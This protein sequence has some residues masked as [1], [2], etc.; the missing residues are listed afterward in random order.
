MIWCYHFETDTVPVQKRRF[1]WDFMQRFFIPGNGTCPAWTTWMMMIWQT[2][3]TSWRS[4]PQWE[5]SG[6]FFWDYRWCSNCANQKPTFTNFCG[7]NNAINHP[8]LGMVNIAPSCGD[9]WGMVYLDF[10]LISSSITVCFLAPQLR[11]RLPCRWLPWTAANLPLGFATP[12][13]LRG[14]I[15]RGSSVSPQRVKRMMTRS[16]LYPD[17]MILD[18][19]YGMILGWYRISGWWFGTFFFTYIGNNHPN[20]L[21]FFRGVAQPPTRYEWTYYILSWGMLLDDPERLYWLLVVSGKIQSVQ[22]RVSWSKDGLGGIADHGKRWA[23]WSFYY[24][25]CCIV[26]Q[27]LWRAKELCVIVASYV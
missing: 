5:N 4:R 12:R 17:W 13:R 22:S 6:D 3:E 14:S 10:L 7:W 21:I 25:F 2:W 8:W 16:R 19:F 20:W 26:W 18:Y 11:R 27:T 9:N 23:K 15:A 1:F 24:A